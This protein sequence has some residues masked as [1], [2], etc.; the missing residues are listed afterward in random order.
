MSFYIYYVIMCMMNTSYVLLHPISEPE[1]FLRRM[2]H[3][4]KRRPPW[5]SEWICVWTIWMETF[6]N[7]GNT[8]WHIFI[9]IYIH[10]CMCLYIYVYIYIHVYVCIDFFGGYIT[11]KY[12]QRT[13]ACC[14]DFQE[15]VMIG[16]CHCRILYLKPWGMC[17]QIRI[18]RYTSYLYVNIYIYVHI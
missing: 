11:G 8:L 9:Y 13:T 1:E 15:M 6:E 12:D 14:G 7:M 16:A 2:V 10:I 18:C 5:A 3:P 4:T 17:T